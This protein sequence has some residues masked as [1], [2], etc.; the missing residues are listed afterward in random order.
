MQ[1]ALN[2]D[3]LFIKPY[4]IFHLLHHLRIQNE[5]KNL[6]SILNVNNSILPK[7][8]L[9]IVACYSSVI[10]VK[11]K[12]IQYII[13]VNEFDGILPNKEIYD[14]SRNIN[15]DLLLEIKD[16]I[17]EIHHIFY[18]VDHPDPLQR[19]AINTSI[20]YADGANI[21]IYHQ[22]FDKYL[23]SKTHGIQLYDM[24]I[25]CNIEKILTYFV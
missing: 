6:L 20:Q 13:N 4:S 8:A 18:G 5:Y 11:I 10:Y 23:I 2:N 1:Q 17:G 25:S 15:N 12:D 7:F 24:D 21:L 16:K 9:Y 22:D 19:N 3:V 14:K